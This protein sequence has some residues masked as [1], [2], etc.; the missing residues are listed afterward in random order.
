MVIGLK[1]WNIKDTYFI[2]TNN[3]TEEIL[4]KEDGKG[5]LE[6]CGPTAAVNCLSA[7]GNNIEIIC[8]GCYEP[9]P[10]A[11][12]LTLARELPATCRDR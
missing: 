5:F 12:S 9:Q 4:R 1:K 7:R 6:T 10:F 3:P 2:Q 8:P 11:H